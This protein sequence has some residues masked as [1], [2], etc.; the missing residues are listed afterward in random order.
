MLKK[1]LAFCIGFIC[2]VYHGYSQTKNIDR[3][4]VSIRQAQTDKQRLSALYLLCEQRLSLST[5]TLYKYAFA[6][7]KLSL[8]AIT[9]EDKALADYYVANYYIKAGYLDSA[10]TLCDRQLI[11]LQNQKSASHTWLKF[12]ALKAQ[13]LVKSNKYKE[14]MAWFYKTLSRAEQTYDTAM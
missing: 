2:T 8:D 10:L 14:G 6:A 5:D 11:I 7:K 9:A 3:L 13:V 12:S 1:I 4:K